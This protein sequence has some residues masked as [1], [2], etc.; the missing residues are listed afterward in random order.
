MKKIF[1]IPEEKRNKIARD[2][3]TSV[4]WSL[5]WAGAEIL[6]DQIQESIAEK[7]LEKKLKDLDLDINE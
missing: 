4:A 3:M 5:I 6:I 1:N 2:F 7:K